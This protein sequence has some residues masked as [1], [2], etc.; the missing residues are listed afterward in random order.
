MAN[1]ENIVKIMNFH[2]LLRVDKAKRTAEKYFAVEKQ[3][4][5]MIAQILYN[6][7]LNLD[8]KMLKENPNGTSLNVYVGNDLGFCGN[9]NSS[10]TKMAHEEKNAKKIMIGEKISSKDEN[11]ILNISKEDFYQ[12]FNQIESIIEPLVKE[13]RLH[14]IHV[15]YNHYYSVNDIRLESIKI[16]PTEISEDTTIDLELDYV[17]EADINELLTQLIILYLC[18]QLRIIESNSWASENIMRERVTRESLKKIADLKEEKAKIERKERKYQSFKKQI[19]NY[20]KLG[21]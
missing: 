17:I 15:I 21:D 8:K 6:K 5:N 9:F 11:V 12:S 1:V 18:Y 13:R 19:S 10:V 2:S 4:T 14:E 16:F 20:R 7:N 3:L